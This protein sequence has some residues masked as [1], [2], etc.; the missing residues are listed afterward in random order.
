MIVKLLGH[1]RVGVSHNLTHLEQIPSFFQ[2]VGGKRVPKAVKG[3]LLGESGPVHG[4]PEH[5]LQATPGILAPSPCFLHQI[6]LRLGAIL[7]ECWIL[8]LFFLQELL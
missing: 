2:G 3:Q 4:P 7:V 6:A 8:L 1:L 5:I